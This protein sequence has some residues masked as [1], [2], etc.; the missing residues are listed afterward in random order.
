MHSN[1]F[2]SLPT[3]ILQQADRFQKNIKSVSQNPSVPT[4]VVLA[5]NGMQIDCEQKDPPIHA[6]ISKQHNEFH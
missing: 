5:Y 1:A 6:L 4:G 2:Y 3:S